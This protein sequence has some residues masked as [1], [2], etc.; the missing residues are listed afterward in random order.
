MH[1]VT[2]A[3]AALVA[4]VSLTWTSEAADPVFVTRNSQPLPAGCA[5]HETAQL[6]ARLA[7]AV[8]AGDL[9]A[10]NRLFV[11]ED[12]PGR[13]TPEQGRAVFQ[14]YSL[15]EG[16]A[17]ASQ[18][19]RHVAFYDR[20]DLFRYFA[21][22]HLLNERWELVSVA[23][24]PSR[25]GGA[26]ITYTIRRTADDL[27]PWLS[28]LGFGKGEIDCAARRIFVWSWAQNDA[29]VDVGAR[30]PRPRGWSPGTAILA[31]TQ[32]LNARPLARD[33]RFSRNPLP[34]R[35]APERALG[36]LRSALRA[37]N[38]GLGDDF[39]R[40]FA[41]DP[42]LASRGTELRSRKRVAAFTHARYNAGEGWTAHALRAP[43]RAR[44]SVAVYR[45]G[46]VVSRPAEIPAPARAVI[47]LDCKSGLIRRWRGP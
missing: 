45:M 33:L 35:C 30:C 25:T 44:Q 34:G 20:V 21:E 29:S 24:T 19:W 7:E 42:L 23:V 16:R 5:P 3:A 1:V 14:W 31:C 40:R 18:P 2:I 37:F 38:S 6:L 11:V 46:L 9:S 41:R 28:A 8:T 32:G 26:A 36:T 10:L 47:T 43:T 4:A 13:A 27:P 39:A 12:P 22:R 17:G 15:T